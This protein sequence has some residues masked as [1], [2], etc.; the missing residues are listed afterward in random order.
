MI[1]NDVSL[2]KINLTLKVIGYSDLKKLHE[3]ET[4]VTFTDLI[5]DKMNFVFLPSTKNTNIEINPIKNLSYKDN[6]IHKII[7]YFDTKFSKNTHVKINLQKNI[8]ME[9]GLGGGSGNAFATLKALCKYYKMKMSKELVTEVSEKFGSDIILFF[10]Q[11]LGIWNSKN[12]TYKEIKSLAPL[13][14]EIYL[15]QYKLSTKE[16]YNKYRESKKINSQT[17]TL[18]EA[19]ITQIFASLKKLNN[20][21]FN[22]LTNSAFLLNSEYQKCYQKLQNIFKKKLN[23]TGSG[24]TFFTIR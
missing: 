13:N 23:M 18:N 17:R 9:S 24:S 5:Q 8:P 21:L 1:I 15:N 10:Y 12:K 3:I 20:L 22:D 7:N 11:T 2:A 16:V 4:L 19:E 14:L 6:L